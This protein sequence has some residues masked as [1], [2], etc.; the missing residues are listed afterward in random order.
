MGQY[1]EVTIT[2]D[3]DT[4]ETAKKV[5]IDLE[6]KIKEFIAKRVKNE[7]FDFHI[8][9][10][11]QIVETVTIYLNSGRSQN[12]EWQAEQIFA[13]MKENFKNELEE[14]NAEMTIPEGIISYCKDDEEEIDEATA[15]IE[16]S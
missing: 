6:S 11:E 13:Y 16:E 8:Q 10:P 1:A 3:F 4:S 15:E 5:C 9:T 7:D 2:A 12:A 14:F